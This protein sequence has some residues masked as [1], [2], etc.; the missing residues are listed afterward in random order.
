MSSD[1]ERRLQ[2]LQGL[3]DQAAKLK[4]AADVLCREVAAQIEESKYKARPDRREQHAP[5]H[6]P[7]R[8]CKR[9]SR[10]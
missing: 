8:R 6:H 3:C 1:E 4:E 9:V 7:E 10:G 2:K 5:A